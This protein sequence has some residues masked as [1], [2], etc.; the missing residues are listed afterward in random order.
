MRVRSS[1]RFKRVISD[2]W[3][4]GEGSNGI[5]GAA[6][7]DR[8]APSRISARQVRNIDGEIPTSMATCISGRPLV[9]SNATA[10]RLNSGENSRL[11]F[12]IAHLQALKGLAKVST[13]SED[14]HSSATRT[15][16]TSSGHVRQDGGKSARAGA[17]VG[18]AA[19]GVKRGLSLGVI[20]PSMFRSRSSAMG[21]TCM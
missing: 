7:L 13:Q 2:A 12:A 5:P 10:S 17:V 16:A 15:A 3:S 6:G 8:A 20:S 9:S 18:Q 11:V 19:R 21:S 14:H 4:A 1:S